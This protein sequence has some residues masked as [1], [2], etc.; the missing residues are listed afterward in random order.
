MLDMTRHRTGHGPACY[1]SGHS[2]L[3]AAISPAG[4][5][6]M[7]DYT[8]IIVPQGHSEP[9]ETVILDRPR[10]VLDAIPALLEANPNCYRIHVY[11]GQTRL[12]S[13]DCTG[14]NVDEV[15]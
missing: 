5:T 9:L 7:G 4:R 13:V 10:E 11:L 8:L 6:D 3:S 14:N 15:E 2:P 12:F 1:G